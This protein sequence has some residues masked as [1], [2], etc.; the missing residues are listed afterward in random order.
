MS[1]RGD[2]NKG[3]AKEERTDRMLYQAGILEGTE[4]SK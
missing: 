1:S 3:R 4:R 2:K